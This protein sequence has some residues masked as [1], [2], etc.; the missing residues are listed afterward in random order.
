M[1][2]IRRILV[3][4]KDPSAKSLPIV[5][6]ATQL[7]RG[8][9]ARLELF[10]CINDPVYSDI[11]APPKQGFQIIEQ[12]WR[13]AFLQRLEAIAVPLRRLGLAV[14]TSVEWDFPVYE[15]IVRRACAIGADLI[16]SECHR[17]RHFVPS[18]L[19]LTDWELLQT[20][21]LPVL[22]VKATRQWSRPVILAAVDPS[23]AFEKPADL[24]SEILRAATVVSEALLGSLHAVHGWVPPPFGAAK[25]KPT[26]ALAV[27]RVAA[28]ARAH[29][30]R[31]F[32]HVLRTT[33][34]PRTRR[35]LIERHALDAIQ[36]AARDTRSAIVVMG[37]VSRS[38][39]KRVF[40]G[41]TAQRLLDALPCDIL[42]VKPRQ[43][44]ARVSRNARGVRLVAVQS[45]D[46]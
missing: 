33:D 36:D 24:D 40:I 34:I 44:R 21:P 19:Q 30:Q 8:L 9:D 35:H 46:L 14:G 38:G 11:A 7:A 37:A 32:E 17:G 42:V 12:D 4:L 28:Q 16:V 25:T 22:L 2:T 23:H 43:F 3:A 18:V 15:A 20:S 13:A 6:K 26:T 1:R 29:A 5:A 27:K 45:L 31:Q 10:H 41:N 39:L